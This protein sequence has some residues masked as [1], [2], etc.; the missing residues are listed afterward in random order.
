MRLV[1][2]L[3]ILLMSKKIVE[4]A[5]QIKIRVRREMR[6]ETRKYLMGNLTNKAE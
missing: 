1:K 4:T 2:K 5:E 6:Q 3:I